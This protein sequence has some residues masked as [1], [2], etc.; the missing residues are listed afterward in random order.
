SAGASFL[1]STA[2]H[3]S[4]VD[5]RD[6]TPVGTAA[7]DILKTDTERSISGGESTGLTMLSGKRRINELVKDDE[8]RKFRIVHVGFRR[9]LSFLE[10][11]S[12]INPS[13]HFQLGLRPLEV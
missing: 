1:R 9:P 12:S 6:F 10:P 2:T 13:H 8:E 3:N 5:V 7:T 11:S 4:N